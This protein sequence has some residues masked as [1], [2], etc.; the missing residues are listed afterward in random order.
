MSKDE[1]EIFKKYAFYFCYPYQAKQYSGTF[2]FIQ[3]LCIVWLCLA[4][5]HREWVFLAGIVVLFLGASNIAEYLNHGNFLRHLDQRGKLSPELQERLV[6]VE[7][8]ESKI[9]EARAKR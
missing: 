9:I 7:A 6:L 1:I 4:L 8:V 2:S 5:W 3:A